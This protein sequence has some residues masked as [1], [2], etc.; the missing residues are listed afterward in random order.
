M[1]MA[2]SESVTNS[3]AFFFIRDDLEKTEGPVEQLAIDNA[4]RSK[5]KEDITSVTYNR[6]HKL[7]VVE[8]FFTECSI[9]ALLPIVLWSAKV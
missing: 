8:P 3:F 4:L 9:P 1:N 5:L 2:S 7:T 6:A